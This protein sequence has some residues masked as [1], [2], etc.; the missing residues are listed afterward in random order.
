M[1]NLD[2][3][4]AAEKMNRAM[5]ELGLGRL[6]PVTLYQLRHSGPST[7]VLNEERPLYEVKKR[8]RWASDKPLK[9]YAKGGRIAEQVA[10]LPR[11]ICSKLVVSES[12]V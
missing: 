11:H 1:C 4:A 3:K 5:Q 7:D 9:R 12:K 6:T 2:V 8:G 10:S